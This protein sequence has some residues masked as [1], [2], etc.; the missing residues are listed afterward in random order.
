ML[1]SQKIAW[2]EAN[3][4]HVEQKQILSEFYVEN[5][6][7]K[8]YNEIKNQHKIDMRRSIGLTEQF[9]DIKD[10]SKDLTL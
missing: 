10:S 7:H 3:P 2:D 8:S 4:S 5:P 9:V 1:A 6:K